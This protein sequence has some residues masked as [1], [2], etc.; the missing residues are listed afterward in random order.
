[1][2]EIKDRYREILG[3]KAVAGWTGTPEETLRYWR[4]RGE[5]PASFKLGRRVVYYRDDVERWLAEQRQASL[6][7]GDAA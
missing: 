6:V 3:I 4:H 5:G 7:G 2:D 1:M